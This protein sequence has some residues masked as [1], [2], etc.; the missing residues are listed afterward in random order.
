MRRRSSGAESDGTNL[1]D[2]SGF[3]AST[4]EQSH[5]ACDEDYM[6]IDDDAPLV[7]V[8]VPPVLSALA[9]PR[10]PP[11]DAF[12]RARA[13]ADA[14]AQIQLLSP[15]ASSRKRPSTAANSFSFSSSPMHAARSPHGGAK[16]ATP[17]PLTRRNL[18]AHILSSSPKHP[19]PVPQPESVSTGS[20]CDVCHLK[21]TQ[22][23]RVL[24]ICQMKTCKLAFHPACVQLHKAPKGQWFC[25]RC[26]LDRKILAKTSVGRLQLQPPSSWGF[27]L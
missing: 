17:S 20:E 6:S 25:N 24:M 27:L 7:A 14:R 12:A 16:T 10:L 1:T 5:A 18:E 15:S 23:N 4:A 3:A 8:T 13:E 19:A 26:Q 21:Q 22:K 2:A 9:V 11:Q